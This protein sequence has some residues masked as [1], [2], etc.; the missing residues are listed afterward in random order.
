MKRAMLL[1][2]LSLAAVALALTPTRAD[3]KPAADRPVLLRTEA[4]KKPAEIA[5]DKQAANAPAPARLLNRDL[6]MERRIIVLIRDPRDSLISYWHQKRVRERT[7]DPDPAGHDERGR[8]VRLRELRPAVRGG[9]GAPAGRPGGRRGHRAAGRAAMI[10]ADS[11][12]VAS[13]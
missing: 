3:D 1:L 2:V 5:A 10:A 11:S 6:L 13:R 8:R 9:V 12:W 7:A 4:E